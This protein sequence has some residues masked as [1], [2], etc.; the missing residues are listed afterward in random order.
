MNNW[1]LVAMAA[2]FAYLCGSIPFGYLAGRQKGIDIREYGSKNIGA[3]NVLRTLGPA[4]AALVFVADVLKGALPVYAVLLL[5]GGSWVQLAAG[6]G[7]LAGHT[8]PV[9]LGFKGGRAVATS[10]G[11]FVVLSPFAALAGLV[12]FAITVAVTRYVSLGSILGSLIAVAAM[13]LF[14]LPMEVTIFGFAVAAL[15]IYRHRPNMVRIKAG[16]ESKIGQR[17]QVPVHKEDERKAGGR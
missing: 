2:V 9:T 5:G 13:P 4:H 6:A 7:A 16:T 11:V 14:G 17:V 3:T 12:V 1:W 10:F 15:I 8:W